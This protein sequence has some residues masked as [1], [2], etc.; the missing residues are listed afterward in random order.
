MLVLGEVK[1]WTN[2][3]FCKGQNEKIP[4]EVVGITQWGRREAEEIAI[5]ISANLFIW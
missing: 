3:L 2:V 5:K 1:Y 4:H